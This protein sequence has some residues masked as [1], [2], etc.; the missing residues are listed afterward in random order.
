MTTDPRSTKG[1]SEHSKNL[2]VYFLDQKRQA[3][4][5]ANPRF[6]NGCHVD[7]SDGAPVT[8]TAQLEYP[9]KGC[10][11]WTVICSACGLR[12]ALTTAG[13][14]DDPRSV[15]VACKGGKAYD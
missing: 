13:R 1:P 5:E 11:I 15:T 8:C 2:K 4:C 14:V 6:P 7:L 3:V 10:G 9:A 12:I